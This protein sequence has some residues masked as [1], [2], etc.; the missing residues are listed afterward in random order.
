[1]T[2]MIIKKARTKRTAVRMRP[3][4]WQ[5]LS[6]LTAITCEQKQDCVARLVR[7]EAIKW[8]VSLPG[9]EAD[10]S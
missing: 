5:L 10:P 8:N 7:A 9:A 2:D 6:I 3:E 4:D 1:M